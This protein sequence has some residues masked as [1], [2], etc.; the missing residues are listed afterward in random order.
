MEATP[1]PNPTLAELAVLVGD[2]SME[3]TNAAFLPTPADAVTGSAT[4]AWIEGGAFLVLY[5]GSQPRGAPAAHWIIGRDE[6]DPSYTVLYA[7]ARGVS[8][9]YGMRFEDGFWELW[10]DNPG[11]SQR[12]AARLSAD[13]NTLSGSWVKSVG[14]ADWEHDFDIT[15]RRVS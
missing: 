11:F 10:R 14:G 3:L 5:Q 8:R 4:F 12:F 13:R 2:W 6:A 1:S 7:D 9:V 15:Y